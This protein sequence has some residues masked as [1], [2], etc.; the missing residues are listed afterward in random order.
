MYILDAHQ[1]IAY[2]TICFGRD[3]RRSAYRKRWLEAGTDIPARAGA[4]T[5]GLPEGMI[6]RV[7]LVFATIFTAPASRQSHPWDAV[8]Y[9]DSQAAYRLAMT[10]MDL[11][12]KLADDEARVQLVR[13]SAEL[14][15]V[16]ATWEPDQPLTERVQG[17][18]I[19]M[20]N[21]DPIQEPRQFEAWYERGVRIV[22]PAWRATR[23]TAGTGA[24][25]RLTDL[26]R[27]L[28]DVLMDFN[29]VLDVSH[30]AEDAF[31]EALDQYAGP[32]I[33]SHSNPRRFCASDRHL[34]DAMIRRLAE[35]DGVMG[36]ALWNRFLDDR[37]RKTDGKRA[38]T[39]TTALDVIDH[40]CQVTGSARHIGIGSD[41]DGGFG[42]ESIPAEI[43][44]VG[45]LWAFREGLAGRG[46]DADAIAAILSGNMLRKLKESLAR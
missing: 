34:D 6:G 1:D 5:L 42:A 40:V 31:Y 37:W 12:H 21:A 36:V 39:L 7:A 15:A 24:P 13:S 10:Q 16:L 25:G 41:L 26:G 2:N 4:V 8:T 20:E 30:M 3:Y 28:L 11:Y 29:V 23:Y 19:L 14:A 27:E 33:A 22:G 43:D 32:V 45:D 18:A 46:F 9:A 17:L 44:T 35:R 38:I